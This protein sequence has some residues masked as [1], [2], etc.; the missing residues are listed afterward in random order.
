MCINASITLILAVVYTGSMYA[1]FAKLFAQRPA[2]M[3][4]ASL[5]PLM[6]A[7]FPWRFLVFGPLYSNLL[8]FGALPLVMVLGL[9]MLEACCTA[10][11]R[12][13]TIAF[14]VVSV[15]GIAITQPNAVFTMG[16]LIAPYMFYQIPAYLDYFK[17]D[18]RRKLWTASVACVLLL[19]IAAVWMALYNASFMQR[20][21]TWQWPSF[22]AKRQ[23]VID[24]V[25]VGFHNAE[26]QILLGLLVLVGLAYTLLHRELLWMSCAYLIMCC[27]YAVSSSTEGRLKNILTGFWY[28][29]QYRLG[30][31]AVLFA[32]PLAGIGIYV[33]LKAAAKLLDGVIGNLANAVN[34]RI[35]S[36]LAAFGI[37]AVNFFPSYYLSGRRDVTTAFGAII[38]DVNYWNSRK[39]PK[40]YTA[41]ESAFVKKVE[42]VIPAGSLVLNQPYDGS[43]YAWGADQLNVY[44]KAW[45]GNWMGAPTETSKLISTKLDKIAQDQSVCAAVQ[46][47]GAE[48]LLVLSQ[49]DY[50]KDKTNPKRMTSLYAFYE[51]SDWEGIDSVTDETPGFTPI[52]SEGDMRLYKISAQCQ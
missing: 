20:T 31:S 25:F 47:T 1:L 51:I 12:V 41:E 46:S 2:L 37:L 11:L 39:K 45:Q 32:A 17:I 43:A 14:F 10:K 40:S 13:K 16:L 33:T 22:E 49:S 52:L 26:P 7:A 27:F 48:Y 30:A 34:R 8:S 29:D 5:T 44:Y 38:S 6:F 3:L 23:S 15:V 4:F 35:L 50:E 9:N 21:V 24:I 18:K 42:Q 19:A 28:H 36:V